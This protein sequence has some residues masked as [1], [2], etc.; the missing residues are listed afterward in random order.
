MLILLKKY[1][2]K[3]CNRAMSCP[4]VYRTWRRSILYWGSWKLWNF[5]ITFSPG[6]KIRNWV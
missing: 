3:L 6:S 1:E 2:V 4:Q 5:T